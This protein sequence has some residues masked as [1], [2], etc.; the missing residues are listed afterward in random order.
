[1]TNQTEHT[2]ELMSSFLGSRTYESYTKLIEGV[3]KHLGELHRAVVDADPH[4]HE[5]REEI[6]NEIATI[7]SVYADAQR[8]FDALRA[9]GIIEGEKLTVS[10]EVD[11]GPVMAR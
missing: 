9:K 5:I 10:V 1:M 4:Y 2:F 8:E 11:S 6:R 7:E 3:E